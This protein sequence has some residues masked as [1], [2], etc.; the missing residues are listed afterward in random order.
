MVV[1]VEM[2]ISCPIIT[3]LQ[4]FV[5][6]LRMADNRLFDKYCAKII[7]IARQYKLANDIPE[8]GSE[9]FVNCK[10]KV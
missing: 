5:V 3:E 6:N 10:V 7:G 8:Y 9:I 2:L 4:N 1:A